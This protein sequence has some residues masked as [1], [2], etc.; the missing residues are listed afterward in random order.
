MD[1][2]GIERAGLLKLNI[3]SAEFDVLTE[4]IVSG[5]IARIDR[6]QIQW[7]A[8][9]EFDECYHFLHEKLLKTH[10]HTW[11]ENPLLWESWTIRK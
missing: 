6:L 11:G 9:P 3:E 8:I 1:T 4:A 7:H 5:T 10:E 2:R